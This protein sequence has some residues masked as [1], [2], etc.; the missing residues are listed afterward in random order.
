MAQKRGLTIERTGAGGSRN[1]GVT[2]IESHLLEEIVVAHDER[3]Y[4]L[5]LFFLHTGS[6]L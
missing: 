5:A 4:P 3:L 1:T 2:S 6:G